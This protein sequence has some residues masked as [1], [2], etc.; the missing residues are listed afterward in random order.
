MDESRSG[1]IRDTDRVNV[2]RERDPLSYGSFAPLLHSFD[3]V[4]KW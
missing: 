2:E 1:S 3:K 4:Q